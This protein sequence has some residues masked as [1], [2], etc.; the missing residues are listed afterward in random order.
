[1]LF[2]DG[3]NLT[4][5]GQEVA[6]QAD[7]RL[8][9][10]SLYLPNVFLWMPDVRSTRDLYAE[11]VQL[12]PEALRAYYYTSLVGDTAR[13]ESAH[14]RLWDLGFHP[15]VFKKAKQDQKAKGVDIA[16]AKDMLL[17][18]IRDHY[19]AAVLMAG[20]GDYLPLVDEVKRMGKLVYVAFFD[21]P[22][23]SPDLRRASDGFVDLTH[24][25]REKWRGFRP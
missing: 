23:L 8:A 3:E 24:L 15:V 12:E 21:A 7:V 22:R 14:D 13:L 9:E 19:D 17:H 4:I 20:D 25:F 6:A 1:M 18:G 11:F 5:R 16:L 10:G 2:V